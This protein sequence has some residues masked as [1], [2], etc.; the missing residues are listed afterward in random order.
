VGQVQ[1]ADQGF[2]VQGRSPGWSTGAWR[3][4]LPGLYSIVDVARW[5]SRR[6]GQR[7][8]AVRL[9]RMGRPTLPY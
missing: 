3:W 2:R 4:E 5:S 8:S 6:G 9:G 7:H 1:A